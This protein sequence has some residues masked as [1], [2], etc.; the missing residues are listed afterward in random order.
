MKIQP[1]MDLQELWFRMD[2]N[3][4]LEF[5]AAEAAA[6]RDLIV[7]DAPAYEWA[8]TA[9]I[10]DVDWFRMLQSATASARTA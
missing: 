4:S 10:E 5:D 3:G 7:R 6:M 9:D 1:T 2:V 8:D